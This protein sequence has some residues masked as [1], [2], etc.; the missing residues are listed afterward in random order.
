MGT[1]ADRGEPYCVDVE[2]IQD[3]LSE[4]NISYFFYTSSK[5][6]ENVREAITQMCQLIFEKIGK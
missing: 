1:K 2:Q 5:T 6:G 3:F 4:Y